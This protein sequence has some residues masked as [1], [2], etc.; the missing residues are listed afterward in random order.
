MTALQLLRQEIIEQ[1]THLADDT[2]STQLEPNEYIRA[3]ATHRTLKDVA[4]RIDDL[5]KAGDAQ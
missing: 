1:M 3:C 4:H 2:I 5:I